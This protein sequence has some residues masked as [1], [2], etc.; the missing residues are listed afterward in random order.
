M[1]AFALKGRARP[2]GSVSTTQE[3]MQ[4]DAE[5]REASK[6]ARTAQVWN[7][8]CFPAATPSSCAWLAVLRPCSSAASASPLPPTVMQPR[9][10]RRLHLQQRTPRRTHSAWTRSST[11]QKTPGERLHPP[12]PAQGRLSLRIMGDGR[13]PAVMHLLQPGGGTCVHAI[14]GAS[15]RDLLAMAALRMQRP[16]SLTMRQPAPAPWV[17][18]R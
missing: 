7:A 17:H 16:A 14:G 4:G 15:R 11:R 2:S 6:E 9:H 8:G 10:C 1:H 18:A 3:R 13:P 5:E 12:L